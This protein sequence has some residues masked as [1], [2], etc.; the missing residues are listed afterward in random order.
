MSA[1][2]ACECLQS[3]PVDVEGDVLQIQQLKEYLQFHST[4]AYLKA[5]SKG[6]MEPYDII[7]QLDIFSEEVRNGTFDSEYDV[8]L[9]IRKLFDGK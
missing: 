7:G 1:Q 2:L 9:S 4:L 3:V 5:G 6:Q 8:Q